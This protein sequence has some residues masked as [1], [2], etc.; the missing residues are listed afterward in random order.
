MAAALFTQAR[1]YWDSVSTNLE[2]QLDL[3]EVLLPQSATVLR[4]LTPPFLR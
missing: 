3:P 2:S 4:R 1:R